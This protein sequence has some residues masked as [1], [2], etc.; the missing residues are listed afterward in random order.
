MEFCIFQI[1]C[2]AHCKGEETGFVASGK[3]GTKA[4]V[5]SLKTAVLTF[6]TVINLLDLSCSC[7]LDGDIY[8]LFTVTCGDNSFPLL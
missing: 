5:Y 4:V 3:G 1:F 6:R 8:F 7:C 2:S